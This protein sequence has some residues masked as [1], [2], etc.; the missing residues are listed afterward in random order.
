MG[1]KHGVWSEDCGLKIREQEVKSMEYRA[2]RMKSRV[3]SI[4]Y[5]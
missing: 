3:C 2:K 5:S 4:K 1:G